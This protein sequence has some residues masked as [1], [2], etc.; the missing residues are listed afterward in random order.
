MKNRI[1]HVGYLTG[2]ILSTAKA[3]EKLGYQ[4]GEIVDDDTQRTRI[5]S[6]TKPDEVRVE[7]VEP[8]EDNKTMQKMLAK[9]GVTPYHICYEVDDVDSEYEQLIQEDWTALFKPVAAPA[10]GNRKIC[11][12]WNSE[13]G[14]IEL[15][16][17]Q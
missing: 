7:L 11:Y 14:F 15:V 6:L 5:C 2:D 12:F 4:M 1:D 8:Y 10:F 9:R 3:F 17:K 16:N 13:I